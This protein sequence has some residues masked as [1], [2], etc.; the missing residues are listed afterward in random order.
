MHTIKAKIQIMTLQAEALSPDMLL[1][2]LD[3]TPL[4]KIAKLSAS[5][6]SVMEIEPVA[7]HTEDVVKSEE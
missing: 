7:Q 5:S 3:G 6:T 2:R 4:I 1:R